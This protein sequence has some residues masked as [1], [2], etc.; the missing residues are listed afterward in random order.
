MWVLFGSFFRVLQLLSIT[1]T[2]QNKMKLVLHERIY[3]VAET[4]GLK[5]GP[6]L[7]SLWLLG[8]HVS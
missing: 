3:D 4:V 6:P 7:L 5:I 1:F 8:V 2:P